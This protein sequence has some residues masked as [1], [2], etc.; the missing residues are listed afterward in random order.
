M[1]LD[2][3]T[4]PGWLQVG[5]G[6]LQLMF[7]II[8]FIEM[9]LRLL[10]EQWN[11]FFG[12]NRYWNV[13]ETFVVVTAA[14]EL[15]GGCGTVGVRPLRLV[16]ILRVFRAVRVVRVF[17]FLR[18]LRL[19]LFSI[20]S[21]FLSFTWALLMLLL[22]MYLFVLAL[23]DTAGSYLEGDDVDDTVREELRT[24]WDGVW[25]GMR[26]LIYSVTGGMDWGDMAAPFWQ[27]HSA[28]GIMY[29]AFIMFTVFGLLNVL[30]GIFVQEAAQLA[31]WDRDLVL[32]DALT[33]EQA[34]IVQMRE[35]FQLIDVDGTGEISFTELE[36]SLDDK[37]IRA[38]FALFEID[39]K[40][41]PEFFSLLDTN[42]DGLVELEEFVE[43]CRRLQG[44][45]KPMEIAQLTGTMRA[46]AL[47]LDKM[48]GAITTNIQRMTRNSQT[49]R[50]NSNLRSS[51]PQIF[52]KGP[53]GSVVDGRR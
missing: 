30:V 12:V 18:Q 42:G 19:M 13:F 24:Y 8:F 2:S 4:V 37:E 16:R 17:R 39:L 34:T 32:D 51:V 22:F 9:T 41:A 5:L 52:P 45:A 23:L 53:Q 50:P 49:E 36:K 28:Y 44:G 27:I 48:E 25:P 6:P 15:F 21:C 33:R 26:S 20:I 29:I 14:I 40:Q 11:F 46:L 31:R 47:R 10:H 35:L 3:G 7:L 1:Y 43:G 38:H